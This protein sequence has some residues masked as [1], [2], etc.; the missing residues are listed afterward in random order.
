MFSQSNTFK[1]F[2]TFFFKFKCNQAT[3]VKIMPLFF[4]TTNA[5]DTLKKNVPKECTSKRT[6]EQLIH[7][8]HRNT[9][10]HCDGLNQHQTMQHCKFSNSIFFFFFDRSLVTQLAA[11]KIPE[12]ERVD[13][14]VCVRNRCHYCS[15]SIIATPRK[16]FEKNALLILIAS[17]RACMC[18]CV[19]R[20]STGRGW[21]RT[22]WSCRL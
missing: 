21:K 6:T 13:F 4:S 17:V 5:C 14:D 7:N 8:C 3:F 19:C 16:K 11:P 20:I 2:V 18:A 12:G 9:C 15:A 10:F 22:F 1:C